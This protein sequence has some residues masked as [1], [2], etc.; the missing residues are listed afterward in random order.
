M[1]PNDNYIIEDFIPFNEVMQYTDVYI[2][3]GGYGGVMLGIQ[4]ALPMVAAG[5][6]E[7]K[8]EICARIGYFR[9]GINLRT[10]YPT[11]VQIRSSV[12]KILAD[13]TYKD[14]V[15]ALA[16][17]FKAYHPGQLATGYIAALLAKQKSAEMN[18]VVNDAAA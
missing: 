1:F 17:E 2:T 13:A 5:V 18:L 7:G 15:S 14:N 4:H 11:P 10:E 9:L 16:S 3:N 8:N 6:H 12:E